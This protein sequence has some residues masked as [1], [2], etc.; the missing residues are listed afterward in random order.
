MKLPRR[1]FLHL[2]TGVAALPAVSRIAWAQAYPTRPVRLVVGFPAGG[3]SDILARLT[4]Q[5]LSERLGQQFI[6]EN[7][8][9]AGG[10][11]GAEAVVRAPPDG[12]TLLSCSSA[13]AVNA[14]IYDKL[15]FVFLRDITPVAAVAKQPQMMVI[16]PTVPTST[17]PEFI[18]YAKLN[19]GKI[20]MASAG[21]G[22][23]PHMTGELFKLMADVDL[24]HVP[25][26]GTGAAYADLLGGRV[27]VAFFGPVSAMEYVK[28]G[29]LRAL[30][31]TGAKRMDTLPDL[32]TVSEFIPGYESTSWFG[33]GAPRSTRTDI[34]EKLN[35]EINAALSDPNMRSR[36]AE[37][38]GHG[39]SR[40]ARRFRQA[41]RRGNRKVGQGDPGGQH[42]AGVTRRHRLDIP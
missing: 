16:N 3:P 6:V 36:I 32:P 29:K 17:V 40:L 20:N 41:H 30:A 31:V 4:A 42:Q 5:W 27:Q 7:R 33:V 21:T 8:A 28:S 11:L 26:R 22:T 34:V 14:T 37:S 38:R 2:A 18:T 23:T 39:P 12:Y 10:S 15:N 25:Y 19:A 9:G 24:V 35:K 1:K 13:D